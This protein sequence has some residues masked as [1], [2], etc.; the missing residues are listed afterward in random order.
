[1]AKSERGNERNKNE[2]DKE[3]K[4]KILGKKSQVGRKHE[5]QMRKCERKQGWKN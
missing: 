2:G 3:S 1:M 4:I 5:S